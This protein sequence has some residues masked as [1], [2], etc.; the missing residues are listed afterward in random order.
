M[1]KSLA[2][3]LLVTLAG[4]VQADD[5][6]TGIKAWE[7]QD[8]AT[9]HQVLGK[10]AA[11]GNAEAQLMV[12]E[13]YGFGEGVPEDMVQ[14]ERWLAKARTGGNQAAAGSLNTLKQ[15]SVRKQDIAYYVSGYKADAAVA[16][17]HCARPVLGNVQAVQTQRQIRAVRDAFVAWEAC[18]K[19]A[20]QALAATAI[21]QGVARLMSL[22]ELQQARTTMDKANAAALAENEREAGAVVAAYNDWA[23]QTRDYAIAIQRG[24]NEWQERLGQRRDFMR[25][26]RRDSVTVA[27]APGSMR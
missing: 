12:G 17:A 15:R 11:A 5:L 13:M 10:L 21:P 23:I 24:L 19:Q 18:Y 3:M 6:A 27:Q 25:D 20:G 7:A 22:S 8:F 2:G 4:V 9:A 26:S 1:K 16:D 14:A